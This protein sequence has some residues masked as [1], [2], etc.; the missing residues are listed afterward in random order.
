MSKNPEGMEILDL[1]QKL[2]YMCKGIP[3]YCIY[4]MNIRKIAK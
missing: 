3:T 4:Y 2:D 1:V